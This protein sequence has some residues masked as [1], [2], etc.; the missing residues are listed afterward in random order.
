MSA[1]E[2]ETDENPYDQG[3]ER[4]KFSKL[5]V[6]QK[7]LGKGAFG[8]VVSAV[9]RA[10]LKEYAVKIIQKNNLDP[11]Q[12]EAFMRE[13]D[14]LR[15]LNHE[16]IVKFVRMIESETR[17]FLVMELI[18]GGQ[19]Q[20]YIKERYQNGNPIN[21]EEASIIMRGI[22]SAINHIH[23]K[24]IIHRDLKPQNILLADKNNLNSIK[25]CDFGL[26]AQYEAD[27]Q[28]AKFTIRCGTRTFMAPELYQKKQYG[29]PIDLWSCG[30][31]LYMLLSG[32]KH[33]LYESS[34]NEETYLVKLENPQWVFPSSFNRY[35]KDLFLKLICHDPIERYTCEHA[36][37]HPWITRRFQDDI[38]L[39]SPEKMRAF[40]HSQTLSRM[41]KTMYMVYKFPGAKVEIDS[42]HRQKIAET[43]D[44]F[45]SLAKKSPTLGGSNFRLFFETNND[46]N[47]E[48]TTATSNPNKESGSGSPA[49]SSSGFSPK[50]PAPI[51]L[52]SQPLLP[53]Q[54][55]TLT[56][57]TKDFE[58]DFNL[59]VE[60][61]RGVT[62]GYMGDNFTLPEAQNTLPGNK[63][64]QF[65]LSV[66]PI[67]FEGPNSKGDEDKKGKND[68]S[69]Q[70]LEPLPPTALDESRV[71]G[72]NI[73]K[74]RTL[75]TDAVKKIHFR[76]HNT[77]IGSVAAGSL[78]F[79]SG[80][81][82]PIVP[83]IASGGNTISVKTVK[84]SPVL[85]SS[86]GPQ[87]AEQLRLTQRTD[88][89]MAKSQVTQKNPSPDSPRTDKNESPV[90]TYNEITQTTTEMKTRSPFIR[91]TVIGSKTVTDD[92]ARD[93][94][95]LKLPSINIE[96]RGRGT[97]TSHKK[98]PIA[99]VAGK[100]HATRFSI[101]PIKGSKDWSP[102]K[103]V[104]T[105]IF[106][107][108]KMG[109]KEHFNFMLDTQ[110][111][112]SFGKKAF[113]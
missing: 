113:Q 91:K 7:V 109:V 87:L 1:S 64:L 83:K 11:V 110:Y 108:D 104:K 78:T 71:N 88:K 96:T 50:Y 4:V 19:L 9:L 105:K 84:K 16:N 44:K 42:T 85:R 69:I 37:N 35:S 46:N 39:T 53:I 32:A 79:A 102:S 33:P 63:K 28:T 6:L 52:N 25:I 36:F 15:Q 22:F 73:R 101:S 100:T 3:D 65:T 14:I 111:A 41:F 40:S 57:N 67:K 86:M 56:E 49:S 43:N 20:E 30:I 72:S 62:M 90:P 8:I 55:T 97:S 98:P 17:V 77:I 107:N 112:S 26:S 80:P 60:R 81:N 29:K 66:M 68:T 59:N 58:G 2:S 54:E 21:D 13:A 82:S 47:L 18:S 12:Y 75:E 74:S 51:L 31:I 106:I 94:K 27:Q 61:K 48:L 89:F 99:D 70:M 10:N 34:D 76:N 103:D 92:K 5:F 93:M 38:P 24:D 45:D 95:S 23:S